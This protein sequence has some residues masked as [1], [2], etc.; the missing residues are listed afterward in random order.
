M[1]SHFQLVWIFS[2]HAHIQTHTRALT[3]VS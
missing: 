2:V 3:V 1:K